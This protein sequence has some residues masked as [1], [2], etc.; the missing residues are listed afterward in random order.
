[1][2]RRKR[3]ILPGMPYHITQRG[4]DG[5]ETFSSIDDRHTYLGLLRMNLLDTRVRL[6]GWCLMTNHVHLIVL[7]ERADS[8]SV[9]M[10]RVHGRYAQ[11]YN[12]HTER[13]GHLW[14]NRF[15]ACLLGSS[16][17]LDGPRLCGAE[18]ATRQTRPAAGRVSLVERTCSRHRWRRYGLARHGMVAL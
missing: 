14:Q 12:A 4:V 16:Q 18:S 11:Y 9:L 8:L 5:R 3:C 7:P 10:R 13:T 2:P 1:M 17:P 15:F 6:L